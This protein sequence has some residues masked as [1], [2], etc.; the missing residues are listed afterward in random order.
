MTHPIP[1]TYY[2][3]TG[4]EKKNHNMTNLSKHKIVRKINVVNKV[5]LRVNVGKIIT[6]TRDVFPNKCRYT[7]SSV[8]GPFW[9]VHKKNSE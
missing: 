4:D 8:R 1:L 5:V 2:N 7:S 9:R 6:T 3:P